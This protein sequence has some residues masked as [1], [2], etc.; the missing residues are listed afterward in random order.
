MVNG[1]KGVGI[2]QLFE[3]MLIER[4]GPQMVDALRTIAKATPHNREI[5]GLRGETLKKLMGVE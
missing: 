4:L 1:L 2:D 5:V 3:A